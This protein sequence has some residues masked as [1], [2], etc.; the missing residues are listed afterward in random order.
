MFLQKAMKQGRT[1]YGISSC[2]ACS[3]IC[4]YNIKGVWSDSM[5][6][7]PTPFLGSPRLN[8]WVEDRPA[9]CCI[10]PIM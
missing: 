4:P 10:W 8:Y 7:M 2:D 5:G 1:V 6:D 9:K 3:K